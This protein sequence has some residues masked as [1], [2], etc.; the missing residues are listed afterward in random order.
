MDYFDESDTSSSFEEGSRRR[1]K[2]FIAWLQEKPN[3]QSLLATVPKPYLCD[4]FNLVDIEQG[5]PM[6]RS[7]EHDLGDL[8]EIIKGE[9]P[10]AEMLKRDGRLVELATTLYLLIHQ[11]YVQTRPGQQAMETIVEGPGRVP[12]RRV[13]CEGTGMIPIG[14]SSGIGG[15]PVRF[16]CPGCREIYVVG[17]G[18]TVTLDGAAFGPN[19]PLMYLMGYKGM[20]GPQIMQGRAENRIYEPRIYGFR[21]R[22]GISTFKGRQKQKY[23][24]KYELDDSNNKTTL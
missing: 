11:R 1:R 15:G 10:S 9:A 4:D 22:Q 20:T 7:S 2:T 13:Y 18:T 3:G 21:V 6:D 12:C 24:Q 19:F 8:L 23:E 5:M 14:E 17:T 16:W